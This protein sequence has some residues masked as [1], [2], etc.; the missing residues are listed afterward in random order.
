MAVARFDTGLRADDRP[1]A[2]TGGRD[3]VAETAAPM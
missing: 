2:N 3:G 1:V